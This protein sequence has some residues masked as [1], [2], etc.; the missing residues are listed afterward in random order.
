MTSA[1]MELQKAVFAVL[2]AD[3]GLLGKLGE[4]RIYDHAPARAEF[5]YLTFGRSTVRDWSTDS[6]EGREHLLT[7]HVW[8]KARGRG[9]TLEL[10]DM[11]RSALADVEPAL[12]GH[13]LVNLRAEFEEARFDD[14][15][16]VYHGLL[17]FR[18]VTEPTS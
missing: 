3:A 11:V 9:E 12:D 10:L 15:F 14:D 13:H 2:S 16:G 18:A 7:I 5:P 6:E 8:S 17:R 4:P 1:A